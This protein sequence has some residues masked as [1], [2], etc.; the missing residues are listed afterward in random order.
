MI[1][2][3]VVDRLVRH[4]GPHFKDTRSLSEDGIAAT[5]LPVDSSVP[6]ADQGWKSHPHKFIGVDAGSPCLTGSAFSITADA[7]GLSTLDYTLPEERE[8][9]ENVHL[10]LHNCLH[11]P[12]ADDVATGLTSGETELDPVGLTAKGVLEQ[13]REDCLETVVALSLIHI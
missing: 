12:D 7:V 5:G 8:T 11:G 13:W 4:L 9:I 3:S 6:E 1:D 10:L 2:T